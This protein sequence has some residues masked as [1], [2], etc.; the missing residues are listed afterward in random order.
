MN[1]YT[2][3]LTDSASVRKYFTAGVIQ[4]REKNCYPFEGLKTHL[5]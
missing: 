5:L 2:G 1:R 4:N 3:K